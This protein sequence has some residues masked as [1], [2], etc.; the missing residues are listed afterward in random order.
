MS[1]SHDPHLPPRDSVLPRAKIDVSLVAIGRGAAAAVAAAVAT[2]ASAAGRPTGG[3]AAGEAA[4]GPL[5]PWVCG[6]CTPSFMEKKLDI[7]LG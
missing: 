2:S 6:G 4:A 7:T 5:E 3:G 1:C